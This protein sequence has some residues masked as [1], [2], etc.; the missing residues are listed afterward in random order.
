MILFWNSEL[1][2]RREKRRSVA[3]TSLGF[4]KN[5][6][7]FFLGCAPVQFEAAVGPLGHAPGSQGGYSAHLALKKKTKNNDQTLGW[8]MSYMIEFILKS[9]T[10]KIQK[11]KDCNRLTQREAIWVC[12]FSLMCF[13]LK[14]K[15]FSTVVAVRNGSM[16]ENFIMMM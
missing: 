12:Q 13:C 7:G 9:L 16:K 15:R 3:T 8:I 14:D 6:L 11:Q 5:F 2:N 10:W 1:S 4:A